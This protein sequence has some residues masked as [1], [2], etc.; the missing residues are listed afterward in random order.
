MLMMALFHP[1]WGERR[2]AFAARANTSMEPCACSALVVIGRGGLGPST[3]V[4]SN[5][6]GTSAHTAGVVGLLNG[7][8]SS[9]LVTSTAPSASLVRSS[10]RIGP[11]YSE[12]LKGQGHC[13]PFSGPTLK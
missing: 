3:D 10:V 7:E 12:E 6:R 9:T 8:L 13:R 11:T 1:H 4:V 2:G 5:V